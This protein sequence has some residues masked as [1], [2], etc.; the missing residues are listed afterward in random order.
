M[1][2]FF[3][4]IFITSTLFILEIIYFRIAGYYNIIDKPNYRSSHTQLTIRGGGIVFPVAILLYVGV[5][6]FTYP[7]FTISLILISFISFCD[8]LKHVPNKIRLLIQ[9]IAVSLLFFQ[10]GVLDISPWIVITS[11]ILAIGAINAYNFMDG[12]NGI[13]GLYSLIAIGTLLYINQRENFVDERLIVITMIALLVFLFFNFRKQA[14]CFAGDVGSVSIAFIILFIL[15]LLIMH[16]QQL[17][18]ILF[19]AVYGVDAIFTIIYRLLNKENIFE[20][21][22]S[23]LYQLMSNE[24]AKGHLMVSAIYAFVQLVINLVVLQVILWH[25]L[26]QIVTAIVIFVALCFTYW[27]TRNRILSNYISGNYKVKR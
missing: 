8:D 21:H 27:Y 15:A 20:A 22:R 11:Y 10:S 16:T 18:Y 25:T 7:Y 23:H 3:F 6:G 24:A 13:T 4:Y 19:L 1:P 2:D 12:I 14:K 9:L 26:A 17:L 5:S